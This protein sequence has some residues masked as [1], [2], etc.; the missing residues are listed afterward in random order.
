MILCNGSA[1][2]PSVPQ[3]NAGNSSDGTPE[4]L[5]YFAMAVL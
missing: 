2:R 4:K 3:A 5:I 1:G